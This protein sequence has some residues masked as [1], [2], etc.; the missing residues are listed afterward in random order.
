M[1]TVEAGERVRCE[2]VCQGGKGRTRKFANL[3]RREGRSGKR[4]MDL[5][6]EIQINIPTKIQGPQGAVTVTALDANHCPGSCMYLIEGRVNGIQKAV[7]VTGDIRAEDWWI[8]ALKRNPLVMKYFPPKSGDSEEKGKAREDD[9]K[10]D[11]ERWPVLDCMYLDTSCVTLNEQFLSKEEAVSELISFMKLYLALDSK[12]TTKFFLNCWTWGYEDILK[13]VAKNFNTKIHFDTYKQRLFSHPTLRSLDPLL[14]ELGTPSHNPNKFHACERRWKCD[15]VWS[16]GIGCYVFND[17]YLPLLRGTEKKYK[18]PGNGD[19]SE[20]GETVYVNPSAVT[21]RGWEGYKKGLLEMIE[22][23]GAG[24]VRGLPNYLIVPLSRHSSLPELKNL[25]SIFKPKTLYPLTIDESCSIYLNLPDLFRDQLH[26]GGHQQS[27]REA[28]SYTEK[29]MERKKERKSSENDLVNIEVLD[30]YVNPDEEEGEKRDE[31]FTCLLNLEGGQEVVDGIKNWVKPP[32]R[33]KP[34]LDEA[35]SSRLPQTS[36]GTSSVYPPPV[37]S[38]ISTLNPSPPKNSAVPNIPPL[39]HPNS[40]LMYPSSSNVTPSSTPLLPSPSISISKSHSKRK[41]KGK[42][43]QAGEDD[44]ENQTLPSLHRS[45]PSSQKVRKPVSFQ[46][47][48]STPILSPELRAL[49]SS[50]LPRVP[51]ITARPS[52]ANRDVRKRIAAAMVKELGGKLRLAGEEIVVIRVQDG[53]DKGS[54]ETVSA[55]DSGSGGN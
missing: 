52:S 18:I 40:S 41:G 35:S 24:V 47:P 33:K 15:Q 37:P 53:G 16:N 29:V 13:G 5:I 49:S 45:S 22:G 51:K 3:R 2:E 50:P 25:V 43:S 20:D 4:G 8:E 10:E 55:S 54:F 28:R 6:K 39:K 12:G 27:R 23:V 21:R 42:Q 36:S 44:T 38:F 9:G 17:E 48:R 19:G 11:A 31:V 7:L 26:S 14:S 1:E 32:S 34:R 46:S 30:C